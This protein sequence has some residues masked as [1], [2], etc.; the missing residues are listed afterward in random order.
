MA[1]TLVSE[2][3]RIT[4]S[5]CALFVLGGYFLHIPHSALQ[6]LYRE[7]FGWYGILWTAWIG[8]PVHE[9]SHAIM[10]KCFN[11]R[12]TAFGLF[13]PNKETGGL[14]FVEHS[15]NP[16]NFWQRLGLFFIGIAP[17][18]GGTLTIATLLFFF[19][20]NGQTILSQIPVPYMEGYDVVETAQHYMGQIIT[21]F[22]SA[23]GSTV[24]IITLYLLCAVASHMIPSKKDI[25]NTLR[26]LPLLLLV[27]TSVIFISFFIGRETHQLVAIFY[28]AL[29]GLFMLELF[30]AG[31]LCIHIL[32]LYP[33][34]LIKRVLQRR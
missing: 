30:I 25:I 10:A 12:I 3:L 5:M 9:C 1:Y 15:Y 14:G 8:T 2:C 6:R 21:L 32:L 13:R 11:H 34:T 33:L 24:G 17:M 4:I 31:M 23:A 29:H 20:P 28:P 18:I 19:M 27:L 16:K 26:G 7:T 22:S